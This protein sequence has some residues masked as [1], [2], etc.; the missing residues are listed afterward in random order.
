MK[1]VLA[2]CRRLQAL[3]TLGLI[4]A[5]LSLGCGG[6]DGMTNPDNPA[7]IRIQN[8]MIGPVIFVF[9]R[10]CGSFQWGEDRLGE[11]E[12]IEPGDDR[13]WTVEAGCWDL[14]ADV[15]NAPA[16]EAT[17][18]LEETNLGNEIAEA[19]EFLWLLGGPGEGDGPA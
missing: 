11:T 14:R 7:T 3:I 6:D 10:S 19:E 2:S 16:G 12:R 17:E 18:I 9:F 1:D 5:A 13:E 4:A 8:N 15:L